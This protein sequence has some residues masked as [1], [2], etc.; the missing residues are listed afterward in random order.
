VLSLLEQGAEKTWRGGMGCVHV[1]QRL[2]TGPIG[3]VR[4]NVRSVSQPRQPGPGIVRHR[5]AAFRYSM[6]VRLFPCR[7]RLGCLVCTS[8]WREF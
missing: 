3:Q 7:G 2:P 5:V 1:P 4:A 6:Q 8:Q